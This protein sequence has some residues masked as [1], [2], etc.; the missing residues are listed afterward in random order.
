MIIEKGST[1]EKIV[2]AT[3]TLLQRE[4]YQKATTKK[5]ADEADVNEVTIFRKF[6]NKKNLI[7][8]T[9][10]YYVNILIER[11]DSMLEYNEEDT[12]DDYLE[13]IYL[14]LVNLPE[15]DV[16]IIKVGMEEVRDVPERKLLIL[17]I[18]NTALDKLEKFFDLK[19]QRGEIRKNINTKILAVNCF[20]VIF[21]S[22]VLWDLYHSDLPLENKKYHDGFLDILDNGI[23]P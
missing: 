1:D 13:K 3:F 12:V 19:V 2:N 17:R 9:K 14:E 5:I 22:I 10:E 7:E 11:L 6:K 18:I 16:N 15:E 23:K 21:Q 4:G 8:V 20:G